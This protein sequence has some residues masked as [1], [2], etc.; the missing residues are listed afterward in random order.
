MEY[1][2]HTGLVGYSTLSQP[3]PAA[4]VRPAIDEP[5]LNQGTNTT[6]VNVNPVNGPELMIALVVYV[7]ALVGIVSLLYLLGNASLRGRWTSPR[8][9]QPRHALRRE[10]RSGYAQRTLAPER[11]RRLHRSGSNL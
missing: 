4:G 5:H 9:G 11:H 3:P 1:L 7:A 10:H 8:P 2:E 6:H